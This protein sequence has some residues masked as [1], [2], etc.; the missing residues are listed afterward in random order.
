MLT[1]KVYQDTRGR[2]HDETT[3][4]FTRKPRVRKGSHTLDEWETQPLLFTQDEE[5]EHTYNRTGVH[6]EIE[7]EG[8]EIFDTMFSWTM[9]VGIIVGLVMKIFG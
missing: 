8:Q 4:K 6:L 9:I 7:R 3:G 1:K 2:L 5:K